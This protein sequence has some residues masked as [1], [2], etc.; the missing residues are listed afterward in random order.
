[1]RAAPL[2]TLKAVLK[3]CRRTEGEDDRRPIE[4][5][6]ARGAEREAIVT[7]MLEMDSHLGDI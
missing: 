4:A 3:G 2:A 5:L 1:M 6:T 7:E